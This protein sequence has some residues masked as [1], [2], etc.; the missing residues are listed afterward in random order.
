MPGWQLV[1]RAL[2]EKKQSALRV[3]TDCSD[4]NEM[5]RTQ[6][7]V[8]GLEE[9]ITVRDTLLAQPKRR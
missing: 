1:L 3:L 8:R 6:G 2:S 7:R 5:F 9:A 4:P